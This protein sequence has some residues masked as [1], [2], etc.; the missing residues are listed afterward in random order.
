VGGGVRVQ[1]NQLMHSVHNAVEVFAPMTLIA[2][3]IQATFALYALFYLLS[4][5]FLINLHWTLN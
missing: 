1:E 4:C 2:A 5:I 3:K